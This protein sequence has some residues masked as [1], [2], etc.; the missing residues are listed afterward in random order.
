VNEESG[1]LH[2]MICGAGGKEVYKNSKTTNDF[3]KKKKRVVE[4]RMR[5]RMDTGGVR[6]D[7]PKSN[8][9]IIR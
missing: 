2:F 5:G 7:E 6:F 3:D 9:A 4:K 1:H 8:F